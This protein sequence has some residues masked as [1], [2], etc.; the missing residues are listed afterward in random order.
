MNKNPETNVITDKMTVP[1][2]RHFLLSA[3]F[4]LPV[5][6][7]VLGTILFRLTDLDMQIQRAFYSA[8][9]G[10]IYKDAA[11]AAFIYHYGNIPALLISLCGLAL[12]VLGFQNAKYLKWR[13]VGLFLLLSM[14]IGPGLIVNLML[15]DNWGRPRPRNVDEFGGKYAFEAV[16]QRDPLSDGKSFPCGH[17]TMG[18]FL[19]VPW[20]VLRNRR[21]TLAIISLFSGIVMGLIIGFVRIVQGGHFASDVLWAG[22]LVYLTAYF[23]F[24][25]LA[26]HKDV[27]YH[28][29]KVKDASQS[30]KRI[31]HLLWLIAVPVI[32]AILLA[33][34]YER[35]QM[36]DLSN[37][38][39][40]MLEFQKAIG[41]VYLKADSS[42]F[43]QMTSNGFGF[44]GSRIKL[45]PK[46]LSDRPT[47]L[48]NQN[49]KGVFTELNTQTNLTLDS[50]QSLQIM[51]KLSKGDLYADLS[52]FEAL[53]FV[54]LGVENGYVHVILPESFEK[55]IY[56]E[57]SA[58]VISD[59][60]DLLYTDDQ[61][62]AAIMIYVN[63]GTLQ[64][65]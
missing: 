36:L 33:S 18:Y 12:I 34:P 62:K 14:I 11:G 6:I 40:E 58:A 51:L 49:K 53:D 23:I 22:V 25:A 61:D 45:I 64:I 9:S 10:W 48:L 39:F 19:F 5:I 31:W 38:S 29:K 17:A 24:R 21:K 3:D 7:L 55:A 47:L 1:R 32:L 41:D 43:A 8:A 65:N 44:P 26:M 4:Y 42:A 50:K 52:G 46:V 2:H 20:F 56:F 63:K 54:S 57:G 27:F 60:K 37:E 35:K 16:L 28:T 30:P 15:K 13:K 59:R